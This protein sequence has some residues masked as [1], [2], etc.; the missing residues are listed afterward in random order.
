MKDAEGLGLSGSPEYA[1]CKARVV[2]LGEEAKVVADMVTVTAG[3]DLA[4]ISKV[5]TLC[6]KMGI[7][8]K[9]ATEYKAAKD[10]VSLLGE[11]G[12]VAEIDAWLTEAR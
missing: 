1:V 9:Y 10:K 6:M 11:Q 7:S 3:A 2:Q 4:A 5:L 8:N 12:K